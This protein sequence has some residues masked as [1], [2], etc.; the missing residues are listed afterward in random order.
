MPCGGIGPMV[1]T[2]DDS[3]K[4]FM[5]QKKSSDLW[6]EEWDTGIHRACLPAFLMSQEGQD[7][8]SHGHE[9]YV[10]PLGATLPTESA[11]LIPKE[12]LYLEALGEIDSILV[13]EMLSDAMR[14]KAIDVVIRAAFSHE[15]ALDR[16]RRLMDLA[17]DRDKAVHDKLILEA[18][19]SQVKSQVD[20]AKT[21]YDERHQRAMEDAQKTFIR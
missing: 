18:L 6:V 5:C 14:Y 9:I 21:Y 1:P 10:P 13:D 16:V 2:D 4:C 3:S 15:G 12:D 7:M 11:P 8:M 19:L 17:H 20:A